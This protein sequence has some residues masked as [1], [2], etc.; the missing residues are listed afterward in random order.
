VRGHEIRQFF[1]EKLIEEK[2]PL[3]LEKRRGI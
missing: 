3:L 1:I 2:R